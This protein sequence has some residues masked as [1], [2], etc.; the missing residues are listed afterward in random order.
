MDL[1]FGRI[2]QSS[3]KTAFWWRSNTSKAHRRVDTCRSS[4]L[5]T[6]GDG[7]AYELAKHG[8]MMGGEVMAQIRGSVVQP[9]REEV[10]AARQNAASFD[11]SGGAMASRTQANRE[12]DFCGPHYGSKTHRMEWCAAASKH[13]CMMCGR[14]QQTWKMPG[15]CDGPSGQGKDSN[16]T[17]KFGA[18]H[19][20]AWHGDESGTK[21]RNSGVV[22]EGFVLHTVPL[23]A[24]AHESLQTSKD[25][26]GRPLQ[27]VEINLDSRQVKGARQKCESGE[28]SHE[29]RVQEVDGRIRSLRCSWRKKVCLKIAKQRRLEDR[30]GVPEEEGDY[31]R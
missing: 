10:Y 7:E 25:G 1:D 31:I 3:P 20:W 29:Q 19:S 17:E 9:K 15:T 13:C 12:V 26:H 28:K 11:L 14:S 8:A 16:S 30:G 18:N 23:Q 22:Q 6:E 4:K 27:N 21:W 24:R 5:F 2:A